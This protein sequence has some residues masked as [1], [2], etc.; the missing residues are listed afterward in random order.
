MPA[1]TSGILQHRT[2]K[3]K[4]AIKEA[5]RSRQSSSWERLKPATVPPPRDKDM[6]HLRK[7]KSSWKLKHESRTKDVNR[8]GGDLLEQKKMM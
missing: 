4:S 7:T 8:R 1:D 5:G 2:L 3:Q 6:V